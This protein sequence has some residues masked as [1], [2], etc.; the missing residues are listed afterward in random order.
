MMMRAK[1]AGEIALYSENSVENV[2][3]T[4]HRPVLLH[5]LRRV[6][7]SLRE[8]QP[9]QTDLVWGEC[10]L[11]LRPGSPEQDLLT[12]RQGAYLLEFGANH[13]ATTKQGYPP[14][15]VDISVCCCDIKPGCAQPMLLPRLGHQ[16]QIL[17]KGQSAAETNDCLDE[18]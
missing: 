12:V 10:E 6:I 11:S 5:Q 2:A 13:L 4:C 8:H 16:V 3:L 17:D 18:R 1:I 14:A 9:P 15:P 7:A